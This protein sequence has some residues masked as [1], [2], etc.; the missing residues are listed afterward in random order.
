MFNILNSYNLMNCILLTWHGKFTQE[1]HNQE[2]KHLSAVLYQISCSSPKM[3]TQSVWVLGL[4]VFVVNR[5]VELI[6]T[7][8]LHRYISS[9]C[10]Y[11][12]VRLLLT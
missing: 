4:F 8:G 2:K 10:G 5:M 12:L 7:G 6:V 9:F 1:S 11:L 3:C